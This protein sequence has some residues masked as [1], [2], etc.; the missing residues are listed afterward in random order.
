VLALILRR[1]GAD[2]APRF[3]VV[4]VN[5]T[6]FRAKSLQFGDYQ[7]SFTE[8]SLGPCKVSMPEL[9]WLRCAP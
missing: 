6:T 8:D 5:G 2:V 7:V 3:T 9:L 4:T 1:P